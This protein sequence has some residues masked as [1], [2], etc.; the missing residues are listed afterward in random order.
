MRIFLLLF[1]VIPLL[2]IVL[3]IQIGSRIGAFATVVWLIAAALIGIN[4]IRLQG[5]ATL[6]Q[7]RQMMGQGNAPAKALANGLLIAIAGVLLIIPGFASDTLALLLIFPPLRSMLIRR[8]LRRVK[9][10][11]AFNGNVYESSRQAEAPPRVAPDA[12]QTI[13]GE[14]KRDD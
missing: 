12:G 14:Y 4:L 11:A 6:T 7:A 5:V 13:E 3:L 8:W 1:I 9:A 10:P 2:E